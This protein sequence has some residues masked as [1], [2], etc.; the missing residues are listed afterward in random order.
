LAIGKDDQSKSSALKFWPNGRNKPMAFVHVM[1]CEQTLPV[2]T[3]EGCEQSKFNM[4]EVDA[5]VRAVTSLI[6][7][8]HVLPSDVAVLSQYRAQCS[9]IKQELQKRGENDVNVSTVIAAQG[10]EWDYVIMSTVRSLPKCSIEKRPTKGWKYQHLGFIADS[11][12]IN[13]ALT[14]AKKGLV[15]IGNKYLLQCDETW[16]KLISHYTEQKKIVNAAEFMP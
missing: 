2:N 13:V 3:S 12:Q 14:R 4:N 16:K 10:S 9:H 8:F 6:R 5:V 1:G 7:R 11:H 15:I